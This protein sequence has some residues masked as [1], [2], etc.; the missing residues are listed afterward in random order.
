M[1]VPDIAPCQA[2]AVAS[3]LQRESDSLRVLGLGP[4]DGGGIVC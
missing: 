4:W 2:S 1:W 3:T